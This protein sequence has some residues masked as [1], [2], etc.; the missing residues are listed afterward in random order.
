MANFGG[1]LG[2][3]PTA[4][5]V[6]RQHQ[7][8]SIDEPLT[9]RTC[10]WRVRRPRSQ[11]APCQRQCET[12]RFQRF[13]DVRAKT[14][15]KQRGQRLC[16]RVNAQALRSKRDAATFT[17]QAPRRQFIQDRFAEDDIKAGVTPGDRVADAI[18]F[19]GVEE[20]NLVRLSHRIISP[21]MSNV[22][23]AIRKDDVG[24]VRGL[25]IA[26]MSA[27]TRALDVSDE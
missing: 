21:K 1:D 6:T 12:L 5:Q 10:D 2:E 27:A 17:Q 14:V 13:S 9:N 25:L 3:Y 23:A 26:E 19:V 24:R 16:S 8:G 7:L 4:T 11:R 20:E 15:S 18:A 22:N